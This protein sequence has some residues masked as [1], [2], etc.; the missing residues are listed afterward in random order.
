MDQVRTAPVLGILGCLALLAALAYPFLL[1]SGGVGAY[2][3][4]AVVNPLVAGLLAL[5][6]VIVL[7]AGRQGRTD[8]GIAAGVALMF[9]LAM[10]VIALLW[11]LTTRVDT[12]EIAASHRWVVAGTATLVPLSGLW[13]T[14]ALGI[15]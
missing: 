2:Y 10:V 15:V 13:Y 8:P 3:N 7:A 12:I 5:V 9:G 4:T 1:G 14:R 11:A 6:A